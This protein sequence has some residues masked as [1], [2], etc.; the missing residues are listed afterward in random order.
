MYA[1]SRR[2]V[3]ALT[4]MAVSV[5]A[6]GSV[7]QASA[8]GT[9]TLLP[10][11]GSGSEVFSVITPTGCGDTNASFYVI[12]LSGGGLTAPI[13]L[14]GVQPLSAIPALADQTTPMTISV[15]LTLDVALGR[16]VQLPGVF[17]IS[18]V[19]R[20]A[21][22]SKP[23]TTFTGKIT[24]FETATGITFA[25]GTQPT[26]VTNS[27]KPKITGEAKVGGTLRVSTGTWS[28]A[29]AATKVIWKVDGKQVGTGT[30]YKVKSSDK[31]KTVVA[32]VEATAA[33][34]ATGKASVSVRIR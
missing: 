25:Q 2:L 23:L 21:L 1:K 28:P 7:P 14:S 6:L 34:L 29:T 3:I 4:S 33:G 30:T 20:G 9:V 19:C 13:N 32:E 15:P 5:L 17:D 8:N 18:V 11:S 12:R 16:G 27:V 26:S 22:A 10:T 24:V 31:G